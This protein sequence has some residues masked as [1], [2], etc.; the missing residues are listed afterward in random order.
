MQ[1]KYH[2]WISVLR[3]EGYNDTFIAEHQNVEGEG[4]I[5]KEFQSP[6]KAVEYFDQLA[7][8]PVKLTETP[9]GAYRVYTEAPVDIVFSRTK[10]QDVRANQLR[11]ECQRLVAEVRQALPAL[12]PLGEWTTRELNVEKLCVIAEQL[13]E[14]SK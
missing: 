8:E 1:N 11:T 5:R 2:G 12:K 13:S 14:L 10:S 3:S 6:A 9:L 4:S 7:G